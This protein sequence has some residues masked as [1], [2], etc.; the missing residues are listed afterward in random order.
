MITSLQC[1]KYIDHHHHFIDETFPKQYVVEIHLAKVISLMSRWLP[2]L[3]MTFAV[4][5]PLVMGTP[6]KANIIPF[7]FFIVDLI[8]EG[9]QPFFQ[10]SFLQISERGKPKDNEGRKTT[11]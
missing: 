2:I 11:K 6:K 1:V 10:A 5:A 4:T 3:P 9:G 8:I 7:E